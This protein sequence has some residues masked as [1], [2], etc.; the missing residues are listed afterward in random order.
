MWGV[1]DILMWECVVTGVSVLSKR[2][3]RPPPKKVECK[4]DIKD[5]IEI[6]LNRAKLR[7][8]KYLCLYKSRTF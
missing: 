1:N 3:K 4:I 6:N 7:N 2:K 5:K 8:G